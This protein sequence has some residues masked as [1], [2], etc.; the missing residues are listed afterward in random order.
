MV[1]AYAF[2]SHVDLVRMEMNGTQHINISKFCSLDKSESKGIIADE[3]LSLVY[4]TGESKPERVIVNE[5][6][7]EDSEL[8]SVHKIINT[9]IKQ[10]MNN[11]WLQIIHSSMSPAILTY[12]SVVKTS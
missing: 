6:S 1:R 4:S 3:K 10:S 9:Y 7:M 12:S 11:L 5:S 2:N 8:E